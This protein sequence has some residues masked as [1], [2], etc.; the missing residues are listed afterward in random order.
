MIPTF[1][2]LTVANEEVA[3]Y[4]TI[5]ALPHSDHYR[6]LFSFTVSEPKTRPTLEVLH[7]T[8]FAPS[9]LKLASTIDLNSELITSV[10]VSSDQPA[11]IEAKPTM[12][13]VKLGWIVGVL[14]GRPPS[15]RLQNTAGRALDPLCVEHLRRDVVPPLVVGDW[16]SGHWSS[17]RYHRHLHGGDSA[18][19]AIDECDLH[20]R[21][22]ERRRNV[23]FDF[24]Q[25]GSGIR[26]CY[27]FDLL[28][29]Q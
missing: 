16:S 6:N 12:D 3:T 19:R 10:M 21:R 9:K 23:L 27:W 15:S 8:A 5:E 22:G 25:F 1:D 26:R 11:S 14:V 29:R 17:V 4:D 13:V 28:V 24:T 20:E 7:G 2:L 18:H